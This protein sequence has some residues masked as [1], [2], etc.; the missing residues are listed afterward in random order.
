MKELFI[1]LQIK[2]VFFVILFFAYFC[3][4]IQSFEN[5]IR[6]KINN[7]IITSLDVEFEKR[8]L[9]ALNPNLKK[10]EQNEIKRISE[11]SIINEKIKEQ[12]INKYFQEKKIPQKYLERLLR[13]IYFKLNISSLE[14]FKIYVDN[15]NINYQNIVRKIT[16]EALWNEI[17]LSKFSSKIKIDDNAILEEINKSK[18]K[19]QKSF[20]MSEI[21]FELN[22][23][24]KLNEKFEEIKKII[25][26]NG[27]E[28]AALKFS[29]SQTNNIGGKLD[30][31]NESSLN[32][33]IRKKINK[34]NVGDYTDPIRVATG[35][36][37]L[38][39]NEIKIEKS[40]ID[41]KSELKKI[42]MLKRNNQLNQF[43]KIYFNKIKKNTLINEV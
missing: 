38:K 36:L 17:I 15:K 8:Y 18:N 11:N 25:Q 2:T 27:F 19:K 29:I 32:K 3:S 23:N 6:Y 34:T 41:I 24:E 33:N 37:I 30:W 14:E 7:E 28:N 16:I 39:I 20:L 4:S 35:F 31:I 22:K 1:K 13:D 12:E 42:K 10:F 21:F 9:L 5:K 40:K 26:N 43:S